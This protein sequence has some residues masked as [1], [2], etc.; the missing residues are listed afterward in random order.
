MIVGTLK[1]EEKPEKTL[2]FE[3]FEDPDLK[4]WTVEGTAFGKEPITKETQGEYQGD[5]K[6]VEKDG[7]IR[8][9]SGFR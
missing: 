3:D 6:V 1:P 4:G 5:Q 9:T 8:I 2:L 7:P